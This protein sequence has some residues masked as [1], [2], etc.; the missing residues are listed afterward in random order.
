MPEDAQSRPDNRPMP[1]GEVGI[2]TMQA[3][4][5]PVLVENIVR[6][7]ARPLKRDKR[8]RWFRMASASAES[9]CSHGAFARL[10]SSSCSRAVPAQL[11]EP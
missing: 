11:R 5:Q 6:G 1:I 4:G 2:A 10:Q 3:H 8:I 9:T 7:T